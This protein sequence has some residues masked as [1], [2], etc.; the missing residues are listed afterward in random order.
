MKSRI[1]PAA[2]AALVALLIALLAT[3]AGALAQRESAVPLRAASCSPVQNP[4]GEL[5]ITSDLPLQGAGR[6]RSEQMASAIAFELARHDWKAGAY[7]LAYQSC[8]DSSGQAGGWDS[9][10]CSA[11]AARY[12]AAASVVA[13]IGTLNSGCAELELPIL[14]RAPNGPLAMISPADTYPGLTHSA[15]GTAAD[16]PERY[17]PTGTRDFAR[18]VASDDSQGAADATLAYDLH[19]RRLFVLHDAQ[20]YGEGIAADTA[21]AAKKLGITVVANVAW[22][23]QAGSYAKLGL[24]IARSG[25]QAVFL[26]GLISENGGRLIEEIRAAAPQVTIIAPDGFT[27]VSTVVAESA[28]GANGSYISVAGLPSERLPPAGQAFVKAFAPSEP[29]AAIDPYA[30]YA[31]QAADVI[32]AAV[33]ASDGT[34]AA[35]ASRLFTVRIRDG[36]L[37]PIAFDA[38]GDLLQSPVTIYKVVAG[39]PAIYQVIVPK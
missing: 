11:N 10:S 4:A 5:L 33:A 31:A 36:L 8:D 15:A 34:R 26:G 28:G 18:L 1:S 17:Y 37:G 38:N 39:K 35:V 16:E 29:G 22:A 25:A 27:P 6:A 7:T 20:A 19:L 12:A 9:S 21:S 14:N 23:A 30:V 24:Q 13:V 3:A 32:L 2:T